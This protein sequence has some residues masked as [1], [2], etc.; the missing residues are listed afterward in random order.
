MPAT[1]SSHAGLWLG[2]FSTVAIFKKKVYI[3]QAR[4]RWPGMSARARGAPPPI[5]TH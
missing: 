3:L 1:K 4:E 2:K 5:Y